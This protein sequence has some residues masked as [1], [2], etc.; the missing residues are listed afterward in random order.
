MYKIGSFIYKKRWF[1]IILILILTIISGFQMKKLRIETS[2]EATLP[3]NSQ[4]MKN[5]NYFKEKFPHHK[6]III[7]VETRDLFSLETIEEIERIT[8]ELEEIEN[9]EKVMSIT[10]AKKIRGSEEGIIIEDLLPEISEEEVSKLKSKIIGDKM[11]EPMLLSKDKKNTLIMVLLSED[12]SNSELYRTY[13]KIKKI[14]KSKILKFYITGEPVVLSELSKYINKNLKKLFPLTIL[15]SIIILWLNFKNV[16]GVLLPI[17]SVL[18][19]IIW[20]MGLQ[21]ALGIPIGVETSMLPL[22]LVTIGIAYGIHILHEFIHSPEKGEKRIST[23]FEKRVKGVLIAGLT[24]VAGF[25]SLLLSS[26]KPIKNMG[27]LNG[28]GVLFI[29]ILS[30]TLIPSVLSFLT[31]KHQNPES[32]DKSKNQKESPLIENLVIKSA[33]KGKYIIV[34]SLL[35]FIFS[36]FLFT[37]Y[38]KTETEPI[39]HFPKNSEIRKAT[40]WVQKNFGIVT[41][42]NMVIENKEGVLKPEILEFIEKVKEKLQKQ[43]LIS[44]T[45][46]LSEITKWLYQAYMNGNP[47]FYKIPQDENV[48]ENLI[49][50]YST[51]VSPEEYESVITPDQTATNVKIF[52]NTSDQRKIKEVIKTIKNLEKPKN[53]KIILTGESVLNLEIDKLI[54]EGQIK[55]IIGAFILVFFITWLILGSFKLGLYAMVPLLFS[56]NY[57]FGF[58]ALVGIALTHSTAIVGNIA[59]GIGIDYT[60]HF[61]TRYKILRG[62]YG[63][64]GSV[65]R[66]IIVNA[67]AVACGFLV[68]VLANLLGIKYLGV[69]VAFVMIISAFASLVILP[70]FLS[71][72]KKEVI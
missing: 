48:I 2:M 5:Y 11:L 38:L 61:L 6:V 30:I 4:V 64:G 47:S 35:I 1:I 36:T 19:G 22:L 21:A 72:I 31:N 63:V 59:V 67:I 46:D 3:Q 66:A 39:K 15:V 69:L 12:I 71:I 43:G 20:I 23:I 58:M 37:N 27:L 32:S 52:L 62:I 7:G 17:F 41:T 45:M 10:R 42:L 40:E 57:L 8:S 24:T 13:Q 68:L 28:L 18:I 65:G 16:I 60:A 44:Q 70:A 53:V 56:V 50:I 14:C 34:I 55:S 54:K 29:L 25:M 26:L 9:V 33:K 51:G 49:F